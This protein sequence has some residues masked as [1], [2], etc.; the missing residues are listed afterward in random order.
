MKVDLNNSLGFSPHVAR[1]IAFIAS[2]RLA[3]PRCCCHFS[4]KGRNVK[5]T[6]NIRK[7][8]IKNSLVH[9]HSFLFKLEDTFGKKNPY[10][11]ERRFSHEDL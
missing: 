9:K 10:S 2:C 7:V 6:G 1:F 4:R 8:V 11:L 5:S 3:L